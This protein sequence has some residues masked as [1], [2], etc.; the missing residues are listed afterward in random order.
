M[1]FEGVDRGKNP[2]LGVAKSAATQAREKDKVR[3]AALCASSAPVTFLWHGKVKHSSGPSIDNQ[4][5]L[6]C[7]LDRT[8]GSAP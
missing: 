4:L 3:G 2:M 7:L 6:G 1:A 8:A 5:E